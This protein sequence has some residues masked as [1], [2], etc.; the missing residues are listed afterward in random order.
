MKQTDTDDLS[1][2][3]IIA[4]PG[5]GDPRFARSVIF[6]CVHSDEGAM[7]LIIN[8]PAPDI[9]FDRLLE[10]LGI[11]ERGGDCPIHLGGPMEAA[12]GFVLH[13]PAMDI[14]GTLEVP[15]LYGM[16][17]TPDILRAIAGGEGPGRALLALGYAGWGPGQLEDELRR[18]DWLVCD[19]TPDLVFS[20]DNGGK[21]M[22]AVRSLGVDPL[23]L[24]AGGRA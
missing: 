17:T 5:L 18:N 7:G 4:M 16:T 19:A 24:S 11:A 6:L 21:W 15:P 14:A 13:A 9:S 10:Q 8:K 23:T 2:R 3:L 12:R 1:G 20:T 22:N